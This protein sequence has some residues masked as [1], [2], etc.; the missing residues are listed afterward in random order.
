MDLYDVMR[1]TFAARQ[2]QDEQVSDSTL[3]HILEN[4]RFAPSGGNRQGWKII[5]I[6]DVKKRASLG[7]IISQVMR[8]YRA[9]VAAGENPYNTVV[10]SQVTQSDID[11]VTLPEGFTE[12]FTHAPILLMVLVDLSVVAS[13]D[14]EL[15]RVGVVSGASIYPFVWNILLAARHEGLGGT[16]TTFTTVHEPEVRKLFNIPANYAVCALLP[17]GKPIKQL[18]KLKRNPV[19]AFT[20]VDTFDGASF[21]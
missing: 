5:V 4:A 18:T 8:R 17:I 20:T 15:D 1:T 19:S 11:A 14:S 13:M 7:P 21:G 9:Q 16:I 10:P 2:F 12:Q 6:K 3:H